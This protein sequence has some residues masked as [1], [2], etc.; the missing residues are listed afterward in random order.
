MHPGE[1]V[2]LAGLLGSGRTE[3]ARLLFGADHADSGTV[4]VDGRPSEAAQPASPPSPRGSPSARR[5]ARTRASIGDLTVRDNIVLALQARRGWARR[6][7]RRTARTSWSTKWIKALD[8]RPAN[9]DAL[10]RNLSGGN[11]QK[12][13]LA[14]WLITEPRLLILD[15]P[16]RGIDIGAKT[17]IQ[18]LVADLAGDGMA[19]L[20][21]SAELEEVLRLSDRVAVLRDRHK[22]AELPRA[23]ASMGEVMELIARGGP[24]SPELWR[25][26]TAVQPVLAGHR[27]G[28]AAACSTRSP[29]RGFFSLRIQDGHLYGS[30]VDILKNGAPTALIALGMTLVIATRGIDL[31]VGATVAIS[32]AV[33]CGWIAAAPDPTSASAAVVGVLLALGLCASCSA[34]GTGSW[35]RC[36]ASSRSSPRWC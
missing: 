11:Q 29:C 6:L 23:E 13:L 20:F 1:V 24:M 35:S 30:L 4:D 5:T 19:V 32:G 22:V 36:W 17:Q 21:I 28:R 31:S 14:R 9:P 7:P 18:K 10:I 8:I 15:E 33:A 3:L 34:S 26:F 27:A 2:G 16:T 12:V 25:R